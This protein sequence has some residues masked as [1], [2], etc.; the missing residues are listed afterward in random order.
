MHENGNLH[1]DDTSNVIVYIRCLSDDILYMGCTS[2][3]YDDVVMG[4]EQQRRN[5]NHN[6]MQEIFFFLGT[7]LGGRRKDIRNS[8]AMDKSTLLLLLLHHKYKWRL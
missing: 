6:K 1:F 7:L 3:G 5:S 8:L 2:F 4:L